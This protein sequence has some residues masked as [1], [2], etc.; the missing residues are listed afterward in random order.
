M[1]S[2]RGLGFL[3]VV[4]RIGNKLPDPVFL[5]LGATLLIMVLSAVGSALDWQVQP[6]K[7][8]VVMETVT[9]ASGV[10][11]RQPK[12]NARGQPEIELIE[13]GAPVK[14][15]NLLSATGIYWLISNMV[16]NFLN[17]PPLGVVVVSMFG[18]GLAER[19]GL[20]GAAMKWV[21]GLVPSKLL[22]PTVV[23]LGIL[24]NVASDAGYIVLPPLA[25]GLY[26]VFKR[27]PMAGIAAAFAGIAGGFSANLL[28]GSTDALVAGI[29]EAGARTLDPAYTVLPTANW[30][31]MI[32]STFLLTLMGWAVTAWVIEPRLAAAAA[33]E[34]A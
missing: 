15:R 26:V 24:S 33:T 34:P 1:S 31:F 9:D 18:I 19:V 17:F 23:M 16:R 8:Q 11:V 29:T 30:Y 6:L 2:A 14:P 12:L 32:A 7:P 13:S 4:E 25:A 5:F 3:N 22:T 21:A 10:E 28:V 27:P 20:F